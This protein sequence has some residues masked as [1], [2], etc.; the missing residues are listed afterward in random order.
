MGEPYLV[1]REYARIDLELAILLQRRFANEFNRQLFAISNYR[2]TN[3]SKILSSF[4][5]D[6]SLKISTTKID[7][8]LVSER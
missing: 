8:S 2:S 1:D 7:I 6:R 4:R 5:A 3:Q